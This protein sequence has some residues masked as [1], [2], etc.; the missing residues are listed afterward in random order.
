MAQRPETPKVSPSRRAPPRRA[1]AT[2]SKAKS[3]GDALPKFVSPC[4]ATLYS[5]VARGEQ[6]LHE[7][8]FDGYRLQ[9]RVDGDDVRLLTRTGLDWTPRFQ[10][11]AEAVRK[12]GVATAVFDGEVVVEDERGASSFTQLVAELK[13]GRSANMAYYVFDLLHLDGVDVT[14]AVLADRKALL[15]TLLHQRA[16]ERDRL[17]FSKHMDGDA[18][19]IFMEAC[20]LGL[21][22]IVSKRRDMPYRS[23]RRDEWRK[24]KCTHSDEFVIGGYIEH[25]SIKGAIGSLAF[26]YWE[27]GRLIYAGRVGTGWNQATAK[28]LWQT[29]QPLRSKAMPFSARPDTTRWRELVF[30]EPELVAQLE[31]R[32][33]SADGIVRHAA[34]KAL[35]EDKRPRDVRRP[36]SIKAI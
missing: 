25:S 27:R 12:L 6:W 18:S 31:Y 32:G 19:R 9:A 17:R 33:W 22:G 11:I 5:E 14:G 16:P 13:A 36:K 10:T 21:E 15:E 24:T 20:K 2:R 29:L 1:K 35:R 23:G 3:G 30:V 28:K 26:G 34:F 8:K 4:L 7:I